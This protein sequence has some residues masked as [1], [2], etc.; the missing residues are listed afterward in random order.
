MG[1]DKYAAPNTTA[2]GRAKNRRVEVRL[3]TNVLGTETP[4]SAQSTAPN[5]SR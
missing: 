2:D 5:P 3:M 1:K 4:S